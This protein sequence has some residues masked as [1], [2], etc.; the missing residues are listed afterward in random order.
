MAEP[1]YATAAEVA[2]RGG[3]G[4]TAEIKA[5]LLMWEAIIDKITH[6]TFSVL[7]PGELTFDGNNG[8]ILHFNIPLVE[9]TAVKVNDSDDA[10]AAADYRAFTGIAAPQDDRGNPKIELR[11]T[12]APSIFNCNHFDHFARGYDQ[13][14][15]AKWGYVDPGDT[16]GT[17]VTP[18][19]IK[20]AAIRLTVMDTQNTTGPGGGAPG[21]VVSPVRRERTD[22]HE[23]EYMEVEDVRL[24]YSMIPR[25]IY[26]T[27]SLY[28]GPLRGAVPD[29]RIFLNPSA[30][31]VTVF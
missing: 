26:D 25:D 14:V 15:T 1:R 13:K 7:D 11:F 24:I 4:S 8:R 6:N 12:S 30:H 21:L 16:P 9:V 19:A 27:L 23:V 2:A 29:P 10:L 17:F 5:R 20:E 3:V 22:D 28:R 31:I 18:P